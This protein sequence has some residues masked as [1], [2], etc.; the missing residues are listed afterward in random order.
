MR[1][2]SSDLSVPGTTLGVY[3][4]SG[5]RFETVQ[6]TAHMLQHLAFKSSLSRSQLMVTRDVQAAGASATAIASRE[7]MVYQVTWRKTRT[8]QKHK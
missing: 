6:G 1:V 5:S 8:R 7:S 2:A 3:V 4:D